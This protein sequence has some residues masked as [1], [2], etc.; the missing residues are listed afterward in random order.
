MNIGKCIRCGGMF[1]ISTNG[2]EVC[3]TCAR[4]SEENYRKIFAYFA[5]RPTATAEEISADTGIDVLE[6]ARFVREKRLRTV[7]TDTGRNCQNCGAAI[8]GGKLSGKL[9]EKC[10]AALGSELQKNT[11]KH[12]SS[13]SKAKPGSSNLQNPLKDSK[14]PKKH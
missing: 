4:E 12:R 9:C 13:G 2:S 1:A 11:M 3:P 7:K 14:K 6:I 10:R 8:Y 5:S